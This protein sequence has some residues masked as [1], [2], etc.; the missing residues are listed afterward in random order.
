MAKHPGSIGKRISGKTSK[1]TYDLIV[2]AGFRNGT[3]PTPCFLRAMS[4]IF[5][6]RQHRQRLLRREG[7]TGDPFA[8]NML[9]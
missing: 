1:H 6:Q 9:A 7:G 2:L 5:Y 4:T 8:E 3:V